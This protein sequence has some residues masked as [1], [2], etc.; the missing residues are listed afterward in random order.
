MNGAR[1]HAFT[2]LLQRHRAGAV[3]A[4]QAVVAADE[5]H[6]L[7]QR[8]AHHVAA[9]GD[10]HGLENH[11]LLE[12]HLLGQRLKRGVDVGSRPLVHALERGLGKLQ[13]NLPAIAADID[14][15]WEV[16]AEAIQTVMR[17]YGVPK[18]YEQLKALTRGKDGITEAV[19]ADFIQKL[20]IPAEAKDRLLKLKPSTYI[21]KA[22]EL[23]K[24]A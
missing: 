5:R 21:G 2:Q 23:A 16:L 15:A 1:I 18:P 22:V 14:S 19:L 3:D 9:D 11:A 12:V 10:A 8:G 24:R 20:E 13:I 7:A 6:G 17:R 4:R